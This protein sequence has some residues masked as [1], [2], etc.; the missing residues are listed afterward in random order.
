MEVVSVVVVDDSTV[1]RM[2]V[3]RALQ[4]LEGVQVQATCRDG[5][6]CLER[7]QLVAPDLVTMDFEMPRMDGMQA[8]REIMALNGKRGSNTQVVMLSTHSKAG[9]DITLQALEAGAMDFIPKPLEGAP[10]NN[11]EQLVGALRG[12]VEVVRQTKRGGNSLKTSGPTLPSIPDIKTIATG[13]TSP[14]TS[15]KGQVSS[16]SHPA[17]SLPKVSLP[18]SQKTGSIQSASAGLIKIKPRAIL[19]G[20]S[21]GGPVALSQLLPKLTQEL[22][23]PILVVQHMPPKFTQSLAESL[24][25]KCSCPVVEAS[26]GQILRGPGVFIAPGGFHLEARKGNGVIEAF[27]HEG[28][29]ENGCRPAVDVLFRSAVTAYEGQVIGIILTGMGSDGAASLAPLAQRGSWIIAQDQAT[30]VVWGMPGSAV[31][32]GTVNQVLPLEDIAGAV[33]RLL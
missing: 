18:I 19:V 33:H 30:S 22:L 10:E 6:A 1:F 27:L 3:S 20:V 28:P 23:L 29:A 31:A 15:G 9:A 8:L 14:K 21:T 25:R 11:F 16:T 12:V 5:L 13:A 24:A 32:T 7:V 4:S 2:V 17:N 26:H